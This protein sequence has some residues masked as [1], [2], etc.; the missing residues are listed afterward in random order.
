M[1]H[2]GRIQYDRRW[3]LLKESNRCAAFAFGPA[4]STTLALSL[5]AAL[6]AAASA[7]RASWQDDLAAQLRWDH[8]RL[9]QYYSGSSNA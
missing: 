2:Q 3:G 1:R 7:A 8:Q 9:V 5:T 6:V 4:V